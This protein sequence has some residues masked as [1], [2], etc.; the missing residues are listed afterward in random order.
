M[1]NAVTDRRRRLIIDRPTKLVIKPID[2][3]NDL[4]KLQ[5]EFLRSVRDAKD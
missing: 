4:G 5:E 2:I 1:R 3:M